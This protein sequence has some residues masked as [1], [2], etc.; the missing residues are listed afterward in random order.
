MGV[1]IDTVRIAGFRGIRNAE[2]SLPGV[3]VLIGTNNSGKTSVIKA[4]QLALGDYSRYLTDEDFHIDSD[5]VRCEEIV[6]DVRVVP[7]DE[8]GMRR[9]DFE[10]DWVR[11]FGDGI[12]PEADGRKFLGIR[13]V[14][15]PDEI[16]GGFVVERYTL[17]TWS[18]FSSWLEEKPKDENQIARRYDALPFVSVDSQRDIHKDLRN[19]TSFVGRIL[20]GVRYD[21]S[22]ISGLEEMVAGINR[23]AVEKSEHL[24]GLRKHLDDLNR[25]FE[26][27]GQ[28]ELTPF[29]KKIRDLSKGFSVHFGETDGNSFSIEYHGMGTR[30]W[31]SMLTV[32]AFADLMAESHERE[33]IPFSPVLAVEE[34]EAHLHPNAQKTLYRQLL[35][36]RG[37]VIISTHSPYLATMASLEQIRRLNKRS[38]GVEAASLPSGLS[39]EDISLLN[40]KIMMSRCDALFAKALILFEGETEEQLI[41]AMFERYYDGRRSTFEKGITCIGVGGKQ[42]RPF[43]IFGCGLGI[44]VCVIS[45]NDDETKKEIESMVN[46]MKEEDGFSLDD[47][48]FSLQ[49]LGENND[50]EAELVNVLQMRKEI[51]EALVSMKT[52]NSDDQGHVDSVK[53]RMN[54]LSDE[55]LLNEIRKGGKKARFAGFLSDVIRRNPNGRKKNEMCP[56]AVA[57]AFRQIE[58]WLEQ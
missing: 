13:T 41:P 12:K 53:E 55:D 8:G 39:P 19:K 34:P 44:P 17:D 46:K 3:A 2:I 48:I 15:R 36:T 35:D 16:K 7:V 9:P 27:A 22:D 50:I 32:K 43:I 52:G 33:E 45:D 31:A 21:E 38:E 26:G 47:D 37:Q 57:R 10:T 25:S 58:E 11:K 42:Y 51:I 5:D 56:E 24:R 54:N 1:L 18:D 23:E 30:S 29:P 28:A 4:L 49:F 40:R 6:V 14:G 20:S